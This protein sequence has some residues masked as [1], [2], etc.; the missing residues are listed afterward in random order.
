[1][2]LAGD[3]ASAL[4]K[5]NN[6]FSLRFVPWS[7]EATNHELEQSDLVVLPQDADS[8]WGRVKRIIG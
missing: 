2:D 3:M 4:G 1:M 8:D 6:Q 5:V 7:L